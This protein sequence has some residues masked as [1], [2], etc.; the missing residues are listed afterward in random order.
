[1]VSSHESTYNHAN[2]NTAYGWG[3]HAGLYDATGTAAGL[4]A[5]FTGTTNITTLGTITTGTWSATA[6]AIDKGGTGQSTA[7]AAIDAL[8]QV[9]G[10]TNEH[11]LTKDT[12]TGNAIW[13][14]SAGGGDE[15]VGVDSGATAGYLGATSNDGVLRVATGLSY[16]DGG[17]Y[18]TLGY[19]IN[20]LAADGS[21][22]GAADYVI[23][24]DDDA[25]SHKK[26]LLNNLPGGAG[27][28]AG[29]QF[30]DRGD[31]AS[32]DWTE[33]TLITD[34]VW[35]DLDCSSIVPAGAVAILFR[36]YIVDDAVGSAFL[37]RKNGNSNVWVGPGCRIQVA[38][39]GADG[40]FIVACDANRV[41][42]YKTSPTTFTNIY[43]T[44]SGWWT[45]GSEITS[46]RCRV[47]MDGDQTISTGSFQKL[48][49]DDIEYDEDNEW[50]TTNKRFVATNAG[51]YI[52]IAQTLIKSLV[53]REYWV[54]RIYVNGAEITLGTNPNA[55]TP[56]SVWIYTY[57]SDILELDAND[58][59][60]IWV[61]HNSGGDRTAPGSEGDHT[62][63]VC[64]IHRIS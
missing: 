36:A 60:E 3:N 63:N 7:Q 42:E 43:L 14:A 41:V 2:Y 57:V 16:T 26:V 39:V 62:K 54:V 6:V 22:N 19:D 51:R 18:V 46:S 48:Q 1:V 61:Y 52:I 31:P 8:T 32:A 49:L 17:D 28:G 23:T 44:V 15:K 9:S 12:A 13:K 24:Y 11:V 40:D 27:A 59:V 21:P 25:G 37:M 5:A 50:D 45:S 56:G 38:N 55:S 29:H 34:N 58:Y 35:R 4:L 30:H 64:A 47:S 53:D 33:A 10:A 20:A